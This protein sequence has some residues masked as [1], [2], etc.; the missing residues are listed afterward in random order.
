MDSAVPLI[1][2]SGFLSEDATSKAAVVDEWRR[3]CERQGFLAIV[4]HQVPQ[5]LQDDMLK[6]MAC[7]FALPMEDKMKAELTKTACNRGYEQLWGQQLEE[8]DQHA[9][10]DKKESFSFRADR[11]PVRFL[12]GKNQWPEGQE[13]FK[14]SCEI[15]YTN[16][17]KLAT[18]LFQITALSLDLPESYF[19]ELAGDTEG[20]SLCRGH[21]YP[22]ASEHSFER[23]AGAH[24][25]FGVMTILLQD[26]VGGLEVMNRTTGKWEKIAPIQ[27]ALV[28]NI[29]DLMQRWTNGRYKSTMHRVISNRSG[30]DRYSVAFFVGISLDTVIKCLPTCLETGETPMHPPVRVEDHLKKRYAQ[31]YGVAGTTIKV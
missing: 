30:L 20:L 12:Q 22:P 13:Q 28:V 17:R 1:D 4:G 31:S 3:T 21:H 27:G 19:D 8:L 18:I 9:A 5:S 24:T 16:L 11:D 29:G 6:A 25:D 14:R 26:Q 7:F 23:G 10:P 2:I 15:Y